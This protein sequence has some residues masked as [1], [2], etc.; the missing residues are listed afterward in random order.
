[1]P[2]TPETVVVNSEGD[3]SPFSRRT[4][5]ADLIDRGRTAETARATTSTIVT[6]LDASGIEAVTTNGIRHAIEEAENGRSLGEVA[7]VLRRA[8]PLALDLATG[9]PPATSLP[10]RG[11]RAR[12]VVTGGT[13]ALDVSF[14]SPLPGL[15][16]RVRVTDLATGLQ[17]ELEAEGDAG[18]VSFGAASIDP[19]FVA[20]DLL[21][22]SGLVLE[23]SLSGMPALP[24]TGGGILGDPAADDEIA[25]K[26]TP[27]EV[28]KLIAVIN[29]LIALHGGI[30]AAL[31][32]IPLFRSAGFMITLK[33]LYDFYASI[34]P[35]VFKGL[36][37]FIRCENE[38]LVEFTVAE[39][40]LLLQGLLV[41][42]QLE[43]E[44][45]EDAKLKKQLQG[46]IKKLGEA[47]AEFK[48]DATKD[49]AIA[50]VM[51]VKSALIANYDL[52]LKG[53]Q[54]YF[55]I[56]VF[57]KLDELGKS[58]A[59]SVFLAYLKGKLKTV[60]LKMLARRIG[61]EAAKKYLP[62]IGLLI[63]LAEAG[64]ALQLT[65]QRIVLEKL[66]DVLLLAAL[67]K[68][69]DLGLGWPQIPNGY[70]F[71][72]DPRYKG[73]KIRMCAWVACAQGVTGS[74]SS[75]KVRFTNFKHCITTTLAPGQT[76]I[77]FDLD[78]ASVA[79][80]ECVKAAKGPC[81]TFLRVTVTPT[82]G[83]P[84]TFD[85][86]VGAKK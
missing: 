8:A 6:S 52:V 68:L 48:L 24:E 44:I 40:K 33:Q 17:D 75:C 4:L 16:L 45:V 12:P 70:L 18:T 49:V 28:R 69:V 19:G 71:F 53:L 76:T 84:F 15:P 9:A 47:I 65:F 55:G 20:I 59:K 46:W 39:L 58:I 35:P 83:D 82:Q 64:A 11:L 67:A 21:A 25:D 61:E 34:P 10:S 2:Q 27:A 1:M 31:D 66:L 7:R 62:G 32:A 81:Y 3:A 73:A 38:H 56:D 42:A 5:L 74:F 85:A 23:T 37:L 79:N 43:L 22:P 36:V 29:Q 72:R 80:S 86:I 26:P 13:R 41:Q 78:P 60:L 77:S 51:A 50:A 63:T 54:D 14:D 57:G 30:N